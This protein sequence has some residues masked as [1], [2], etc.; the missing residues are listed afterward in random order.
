MGSVL[1]WLLVAL[2]ERERESKNKMAKKKLSLDVWCVVKWYCI[3][4]KIVF[5]MLVVGCFKGERERERE[6]KNKMAKKN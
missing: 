2:R 4:D 6:S 3:I 1:L 5:E